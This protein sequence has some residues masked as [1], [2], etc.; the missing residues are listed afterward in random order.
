MFNHFKTS[1]D[2]NMAVRLFDTAFAPVTGVAQASTTVTLAK[3]PS[4]TPSA[5]T[6]TTHYTWTE[7]VTGAFST[8]GVYKLTILAS[9]ISTPG[10]YTVA[11]TGGTGKAVIQFSVHDNY[12]SDVYTRLG[13]P[14]FT[15]VVGDIANVKA[16]LGVPTLTVSGDIA[17]VKSDTGTINTR[18]GAPVG[19]SISADIAAVKSETS[20]IN[21]YTNSINTKI[22]TP[23]AASVSAD[24]AAVKSDTGTINT[25]TGTINTTTGTINTKLGTPAGASVSAD[26]VAVKADTGSA[27]SQATTA[28]T[29]STTAANNTTAIDTK[30]GTPAGASVS[31]DIAAVQTDIDTANTDV[32][33]VKKY[34]Q[35]TWYIYTTGPDANRLVIFDDDGIT[36]LIK[37]DLKDSVGSATTTNPFRRVKVP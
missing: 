31:A 25:V 17:A 4:M 36:P 19:A 23:V 10:E 7:L 3:T 37:F 14:N 35:G 30:L 26:I 24:I 6:A 34:L 28:A 18:V 12:T 33:L 5:L 32:T 29:Q 21:S 9:Q 8:Q 22:G 16:V 20:T 2:V 27:L 15:S 1:V 11:I 13:A